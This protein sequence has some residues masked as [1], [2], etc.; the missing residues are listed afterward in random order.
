MKTFNKTRFEEIQVTLLILRNRRL[1]TC[2]GVRIDGRNICRGGSLRA[3]LALAPGYGTRRKR[4]SVCSSSRVVTIF[5]LR[6][7]LLSEAD[8]Q[9]IDAAEQAAAL[10]GAPRRKFV[11]VDDMLSALDFRR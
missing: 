7:R 9:T 4:N 8:W 6:R 3:P 1:K 5:L 11:K 2:I 10:P